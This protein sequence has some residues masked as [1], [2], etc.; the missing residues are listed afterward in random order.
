MVN[1]LDP[2]KIR[3]LKNNLSVYAKGMNML[4]IFNMDYK[5]VKPITVDAVFICPP[6][7]GIDIS[8]YSCR[9]LDDI[10]NPRLSDILTHCKKFSKNMVLQMPKNTNLSNLMKVIN[11]CFLSPIIKI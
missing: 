10:M 5:N 8:E 9:D 3:M 7:G 2:N 1:D 11:M 4:K 6:W